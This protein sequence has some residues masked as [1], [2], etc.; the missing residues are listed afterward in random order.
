MKY[1]YQITDEVNVK[2][3][4]IGKIKD[5]Q[6]SRI[7]NEDIPSY[8]ILF[9]KEIYPDNQPRNILESSITGIHKRQLKFEGIDDWNRP[10]FK[11]HN[12]NRFG[13]TENLFK[14]DSTF[15]M[16][17]SKIS[18][19]HICYFGSTFNCEPT[20]TLINPN[21]IKLVKEWEE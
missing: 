1:K 20:G 8:W 18:E 9:N 14:W 10:V 17:T 15:E 16:V 6:V 21:K 2:D 13:D 5:F 12:N 11:D 19:K 4:G 7:D 3:V